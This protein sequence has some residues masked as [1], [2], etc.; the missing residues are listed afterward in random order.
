VEVA[1]YRVVS[2]A[3]TNALR[4]AR[5]SVCTVDL[6]AADGGLLLEV[7]DD[8]AGIAPDAVPHVGLES[9]RERA[10]EVGGRLEI[11]TGAHGT[12]VRAWLP[13]EV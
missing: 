4:H 13:L 8:G 2:E 6:G 11:D 3:V 9:M 12:T 5:C 10:V 7:R 1:A